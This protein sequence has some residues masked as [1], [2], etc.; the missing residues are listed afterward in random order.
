ML[1]WLFAVFIV[2]VIHR[3]SYKKHENKRNSLHCCKHDVMTLYRYVS[4]IPLVAKGVEKEKSGSQNL[5]FWSQK[6]E[7]LP[8]VPQK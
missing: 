7:K 1:C 8:K 5:P 6:R 4:Y 2:V 3:F